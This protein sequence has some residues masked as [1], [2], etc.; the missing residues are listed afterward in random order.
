MGSV[1]FKNTVLFIAICL[2]SL[3]IYAYNLN[4]L[5]NEGMSNLIHFDGTDD[6]DQYRFLDRMLDEVFN[7]KKEGKTKLVPVFLKSD[8][9]LYGVVAISHE[10]TGKPKKERVHLFPVVAPFVKDSSKVAVELL[11]A[12]ARGLKDKEIIVPQSVAELDGF[13]EYSGSSKAEAPAFKLVETSDHFALLKVNSYKSDFEVVDIEDNKLLAYKIL[14]SIYSQILMDFDSNVFSNYKSFIDFATIEKE[15]LV[16]LHN[17]FTVINQNETTSLEMVSFMDYVESF[18]YIEKA[19][20]I[21]SKYKPD[22][23]KY[24]SRPKLYPISEFYINMIE[25]FAGSIDYLK[26]VRMIMDRF[27]SGSQIRF[28]S[29][30]TALFK[31]K[32]DERTNIGIGVLSDIL[33]YLNQASKDKDRRR[34][35]LFSVAMSK[36]RA[37]V[38]DSLRQKDILVRARVSKNSGSDNKVKFYLTDDNFLLDELLNDEGKFQELSLYTSSEQLMQ[39]AEDLSLKGILEYLKQML[40]DTLF[41]EVK[42]Y[43]KHREN[44]FSLMASKSDL[45][46]LYWVYTLFEEGIKRIN[47]DNLS[48]LDIAHIA[49]LISVLQLPQVLAIPAEYKSELLSAVKDFKTAII[50]RAF[51]EKGRDLTQ[52]ESYLVSKTNAFIREINEEIK[53]IEALEAELDMDIDLDDDCSGL[54]GEDID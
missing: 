21:F 53:A 9:N 17:Q 3:D 31:R 2:L 54:F 48:V 12:V 28:D 30:L 27:F 23:Y 13:L 1:M 19:S 47:V 38:Y 25:N 24:V 50:I 36:F 39:V 11:N 42:E 51:Q 52:A 6:T 43:L 46:S 35:K 10:I 7:P 8:N 18:Y 20:T 29:K 45:T 4:P 34:A 14:S 22:V 15:S 16:S 49:I 33:T 44:I 5:N 40:P 26:F 37:S 41:S 32:L